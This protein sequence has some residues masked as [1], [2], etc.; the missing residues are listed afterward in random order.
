MTTP[1]P[2]WQKL[3]V[4]ATAPVV[5]ALLA[6]L[7]LN[8]VSTIVQYRREDIKLRESLITE[9]AEIFSAMEA[10]INSF[11]N[12]YSEKRK[13]KDL[14]ADEFKTRWAE[15]EQAFADARSA[16]VVTIRLQLYFS[17]PEPAMR[18]ASAIRTLRLHYLEIRENTRKQQQLLKQGISSGEE[19]FQ[20]A[21]GA[22]AHIDTTKNARKDFRASAQNIWSST[23]DRAGRI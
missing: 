8:R 3:L 23:L 22:D 20:V 6:L 13:L 2:L 1:E 9:M 10:S 21:I 15:L 4:S 16:D 19:L 14:E 17:T 18:W 12:V 11:F 7:V 5:T